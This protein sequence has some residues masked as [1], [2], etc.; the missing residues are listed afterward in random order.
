MK[1][2]IHIVFLFLS[3][4]ALLLIGHDYVYGHFDDDQL[5]C[6]NCLLCKAFQSTELGSDFPAMFLFFGIMPVI[7]F[8]SL[9]IWFKPHSIYLLAISLR[10]PP[11]QKN[12]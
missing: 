3:L 9:Y 6:N 5:C 11:S 2:K 4:C 7:G 12:L 10:A 8:F 1:K